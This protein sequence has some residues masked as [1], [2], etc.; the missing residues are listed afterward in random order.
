MVKYILMIE[1]LLKNNNY[2]Q[3]ATLCGC[4]RMTVWR[5][6]QR[7]DFLN[8]SLDEINE[9]QEE[10]LR[11]LLFPERIKKAT[12]ICSPILNGKNFKCGNINLHFGYV[13]EDIANAL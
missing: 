10:E 6:L 9:M 13:G 12:V 1:Y 7:I 2:S 11:F 8:I 4:S 3:V 5:V